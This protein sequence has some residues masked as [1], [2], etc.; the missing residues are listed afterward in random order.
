VVVQGDAWS[1]EHLLASNPSDPNH[2]VVAD[3]EMSAE[4]HGGLRNTIAVRASRDGGRTWTEGDF[5]GDHA[6]EPGH[7]FFGAR[8]FVDPFAAILDDGT[9]LVGGLTTTYAWPTIQGTDVFVARSYDGGLTFPDIQIIAEGAGVFPGPARINDH[10]FIDVGKDGTIIVSWVYLDLI[11]AAR[12]P[13]DQD[14]ADP[15]RN[16]VPMD[17]RFSVSRDGG[18]TWTAPGTAAIGGYVDHLAPASTAVAG[19]GTLVIAGVKRREHASPPE[20]DPIGWTQWSTGG[21]GQGNLALVTSQDG[22]ESW[23]TRIVDGIYAMSGMVSVQIAETKGHEYLYV[24]YNKKTPD[25]IVPML[26]VSQD[27]GKT[28]NLIE[29]SHHPRGLSP[30][31][32]SFG[33]DGRGVAYVAQVDQHDGSYDVVVVAASPQGLLG[34]TTLESLDSDAGPAHYWGVTGLDRGAYVMWNSPSEEA[35][36]NSQVFNSGA[37]DFDLRGARVWLD[38]GPR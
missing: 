3:M 13:P 35:G 6:L 26:G 11:T 5:P 20:E 37:Q 12:V 22:G 28:W 16:V 19:D 27:L 1:F 31:G 14:R 7:P 2:L 25:R 4:V 18:E 10:P 21:D 33:V 34:R 32:P 36:P 15:E 8:D 23:D 30:S 29:L 24:G 9:V 17:L 38:G